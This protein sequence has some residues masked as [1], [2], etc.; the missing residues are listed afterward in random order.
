MTGPSTGRSRAK[1][2][3]PHV[4]VAAKEYVSSNSTSAMFLGGQQKSWMTGIKDVEVDTYR[5]PSKSNIERKA[6]I[7]RERSSIQPSLNTTT[8]NLNNTPS[9]PNYPSGNDQSPLADN[10]LNQIG[11]DKTSLRKPSASAVYN[12]ETV[13]PSPAPSDEHR[14]DNIRAHDSEIHGQIFNVHGNSDQ[15]ISNIHQEENEQ[16]DRMLRDA[17]SA[18]TPPASDTT[19]FQAQQLPTQLP[20]ATVARPMSHQGP[21]ERKRKRNDTGLETSDLGTRPSHSPPKTA[22]P[23]NT[24][25]P[26]QRRQAP[27]DVQMSGFQQIVIDRQQQRAIISAPGDTEVARLNLLQRAFMQ[28]DHM[29]ILLHQIYCMDVTQPRFSKQLQDVGFRNEHV[30]GLGMLVPLLLPNFQSIAPDSVHWFAY[31]PLSFALM[32]GEYEIYR[33]AMESVKTCLILFNHGWLA[34]RERCNKR[35]YPPLVEEL[36]QVLGIGSPVL[37]SVVFRAILKDMWMGNTNDSCFNEGEALF[38]QDQQL[39]QQSRSQPDS[40]RDN[41][42]LIMKYQQLHATHKKHPRRSGSNASPSNLKG[43]VTSQY[44]HTSRTSPSPP[45]PPSSS[46]YHGE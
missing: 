10:C 17:L 43:P 30:T 44:Q 27:T 12:V 46:S 24:A 4:N 42:H 33:K 6:R 41:Q 45:P 3:L 37:Q 18:T 23:S 8:A 38:H 20:S 22:N 35:T 14:P 13:L 31:F 5:G 11:R 1:N 29:Y 2:S 26:A 39:M 32:L 9:F 34:Y 40:R 19:I 36:V 25:V 28:H 15:T 7:I 16:F 21:S